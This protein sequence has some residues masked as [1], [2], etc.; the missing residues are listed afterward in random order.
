MQPIETFKKNRYTVLIYLDP[1]P[2]N[3]RQDDNTAV[4][5]CFHKRYNL[6]DLDHGYDY[7]D[8]SGWA[9]F[10]AQLE[11]DHKPAA[12]LPL[13]LIDHSGISMYIGGGA[14]PCDPGGW[15]SGT[16]GFGF[17]SRETALRE[18]GS[19]RLT[20]RIRKQAETCLRAEVETYNQY[21]TGD[22]YG[23]EI[24]DENGELIDSCWGFYGVECCREEALACVP[25]PPDWDEIISGPELPTVAEVS[26]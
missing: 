21:L 20:K 14:H 26:Q 17:V 23:Y 13:G 1:D 18:W 11:K 15:D 22:V 2:T 6:G 3:P 8:Y 4:L 19:K 7:R 9:E 12:I 24:Q 16:I 10:R 5:V 25:V